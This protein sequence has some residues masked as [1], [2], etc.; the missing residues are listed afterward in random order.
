M[1]RLAL[2][3][4]QATIRL[5]RWP[6]RRVAAWRD[7]IAAVAGVVG[8][9]IAMLVGALMDGRLIGAQLTQELGIGP[10]FH[11][12]SR[13]KSSCSR[14]SRRSEPS[15]LMTYVPFGRCWKSS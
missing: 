7:R 5:A 2:L 6:R 12:N 10:A 13:R 15:A 14:T 11:S 3:P 4:T 9:P 1:T 8:L